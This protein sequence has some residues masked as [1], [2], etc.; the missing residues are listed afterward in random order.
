[1]KR[2]TTPSFIQEFELLE[3]RSG[4]FR[5]LDQVEDHS[6]RLFNAL[7]GKLKRRVTKMKSSEEWKEARALPKGSVARSEAFRAILIREELTELQVDRV[8]KELRQGE[9]KVFVGSH[10]AQKIGIRAF[11]AISKLISGKGKRV[12]FKKQSEFFSFEGKDNRSFLKLV[13]SDEDIPQIKLMNHT[14]HLRVDPKCEYQKHALSSRCK[15]VRIAKRRIRG[16]VRY[17]AQ[18]VCEGRPYHDVRKSERHQSKMKQFKRDESLTADIKRI[19]PRFENVVCLDFGPKKVAVSTSHDGF[20]RNICEGLLS[21][22][23]KIR[24]LQRGLDRSRRSMNPEN[25]NPDGTCK[26]GRKTWKESKRYLKL[27]AELGNDYRRQ[28]AHRKSVQGELANDI[29]ALG[30]CIKV[31][32]VSYKGF[33][34]SYGKAIGMHAPSN[35][36]GM[37]TRK[38]AN[39]RGRVELINTFQTKLSQTCIC[40]NQQKKPLHQRQH[41]CDQCLIGTQGNFISRD[42]FSAFLGVFTENHETKKGKKVTYSSL[43]NLKQANLAIQGHRILSSVGLKEQLQTQTSKDDSIEGVEQSTAEGST[44]IALSPFLESEIFQRSSESGRGWKQKN[45]PL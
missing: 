24:L 34:K 12:R 13:F 30:N 41:R 39:A 17:F 22:R 45:L 25:F 11:A 21:K 14:Y 4:G 3:P 20:E 5:E 7:A 42:L 31:E 32:K 15:Y 44:G 10:V 23:K 9:F 6:R 40:G 19:D 1:M 28:A 2:V 18:L 37:L 33:Q 29:L 35:L 36:Q 26:K 43:L 16:Q 8:V 27:K 38:A